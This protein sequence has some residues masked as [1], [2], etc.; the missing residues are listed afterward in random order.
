MSSP[1]TL[2][3]FKQAERITRVERETYADRQWL[4]QANTRGERSANEIYAEAHAWWDRA[5]AIVDAAVETW[6]SSCA[7]SDALDE[8]PFNGR[9]CAELCR[10]WQ[11][12]EKKLRALERGEGSEGQP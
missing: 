3:T 10:K 9:L 5:R 4:A 2:M 12:S 11:A 6:E 1:M 7:Y 8:E